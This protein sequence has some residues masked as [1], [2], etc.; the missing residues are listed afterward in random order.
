LRNRILRILTILFFGVLTTA[1]WA[2]ETHN[3]FN[4]YNYFVGGGLGIGRDDV[5]SY[6]G[7][8]FFGVIGGGKN[9]SRLFGADAEYMYYDLGFRPSVI[10][11]QGLPGQSGDMQSISLDGIFNVPKHIG[12]LG[13]Y[14]ICG[15][16][17]YRRAV[18]TDTH[19]LPAEAINQPAYRWWDLA[20]DPQGNILPQYIHEKVKVAG[21]FNYGGGITYQLD[22][23]HHAR[24]FGEFRYH[25]AYQADGQTIVMPLTVG[26]RW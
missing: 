21:G 16:G 3:T 6:V 18:S 2:Q 22:H 17:F 19:F 1:G 20:L 9:F 7:N 26:L 11:S 14:G 15:V 13:A 25:R 24:L 5:A 10:Q 4:P 8:S 23:F 12:K